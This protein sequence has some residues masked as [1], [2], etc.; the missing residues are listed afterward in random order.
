M[1]FVQEQGDGVRSFVGL[2]IALT[3]GRYP[4]IFVD[5]PEAFLHPP[6]ARLLGRKLASEVPDGTQLFVA[7][8]SIDVL[9]GLL[10][11]PEAD[12]TIIR[13]IREGD[14]NPASVLVPDQVRELWRDPLLRYSN[15][16]DGLFHR[17]VVLCESDSDARFYAAVLDA[18]RADAGVGE[19]NLLFTHCGGKQRMPVV[20]QSLRAVN[21]P[22]AVVADFDVLRERPLLER[23]VQL[24]GGDWADVEPTWSPVQAAV[25]NMGAAPLVATVRE[26]LEQVI[27][28]A[29]ERS[30]RLTREDVDRV[31]NVTRVDDGWSIAKR[32]GVAVLPGGDAS[33]RATALL[34]QLRESGIFVVDVGELERWAPEIG[35]H[36]PSWVVNVLD[37]AR[38]EDPELPAR[39]FMHRVDAF[40]HG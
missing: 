31:R 25:D 18:A 35:G 11:V 14:T 6:Q 21:V 33:E 28:A 19:H 32:G 4:L 36:G 20:L 29:A 38:H 10:A 12:V 1:P 40:L 7:T 8:H 34:E 39:G 16:L 24:A 22:M 37:G 27:T 2:M 23:L 26:G 3:A 17:G 13:L 30:P 5:E 9:Q 15:V